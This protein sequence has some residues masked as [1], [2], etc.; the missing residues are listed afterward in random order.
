MGSKVN[1]AQIS[2]MAKALQEFG[3]PSVTPAIVRQQVD[4]LEQGEQPGNVIAMFCK[5]WLE[6]ANLL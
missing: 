6:E 4:A 2:A 5:D 3:Y 1:D